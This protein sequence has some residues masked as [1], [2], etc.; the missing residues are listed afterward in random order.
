MWVRWRGTVTTTGDPTAKVSPATNTLTVRLH[1]NN[2]GSPGTVLETMTKAVTDA[3]D[4]VSQ[5][6][7]FVFSGVQT[8]TNGTTYHFT[9]T[10][11]TTSNKASHWEVAVDPT[12][13]SSKI[14]ADMSSPASATWAAPA[15]TFSL[16][17][18][19]ADAET[20]RKFFPF[21]LDNH[22]YAV[23]V[24]D[25]GVTASKLYINGDR[26][27]ATS[28][29]STTLTDTAFGVRAAGWTTSMWVNAKVRIVRGTGKGQVRKITANTTD[30]LTVGT[31][32]TTPD[33]TS[34][35]VIYS[36]PEWQELTVTGLG[37]V[38]GEPAVLGNIVYFPQGTTAIREMTLDYT[39]ATNHKYR[40]E[41]TNT[42]N[43]LLT[44]YN[45]QTNTAIVWRALNSSTAAT[46][47]F[48]PAVTWGSDLTF[49]T[50]INAGDSSFLI[51]GL[52]EKDNTLQIFK[53][54]GIGFISGN[55]Y[56]TIKSGQEDTPDDTNGIAS[57]AVDKFLYYNWLHSVIRVYGSSYDD[58]GQDYSSF[59]LPDFR[60]GVISYLDAYITTVL[61]AVDAGDGLTGKRPGSGISSVQMWDG[62]AW[63]ELFR[64]WQNGR[65]IRMA[66]VQPCPE[67]RNII[68]IDCGGEMIYLEMPLQKRD[69][70]L[71]SGMLYQHESVVESSI[72]DM[73][74][75]SD[76]PKMIKSLTATVKNLNAEGMEVYLD[77]QTDGDC[78]TATWVPASVLTQSPESTAW[79]GLQNIR[80]FVYRLRM[81]TDDATIPCD[82][83]GIV[84]SGY[85][86]TPLKL[87]WT[88]RVKAGGIYQSNS[89][90]APNSQ[91]LW[92]WL[93]DNARFPFAVLM[94]SKYEA[95]DGYHVIVH[96]PRMTPYKPAEPGQPEESYMSLVLEEI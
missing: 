70:L 35:Y 44:S 20:Q 29:T 38:T 83:E 68:W 84:P 22:M 81:C 62:L 52:N 79:L 74:A 60:E 12:G 30:T 9:V 80:R 40:S 14:T 47:S 31:W 61:A 37:V 24:K 55:A 13:T 54:N 71:D 15:S 42:A 43:L 72:I 53:Q 67:S 23:D 36:T 48:A 57:V 19:V 92:K 6:L 26:G 28:A 7:Q 96:P 49:G 76:M 56:V 88:M 93:M 21:F 32:D 85:A 17:Y 39:A 64:G 25:N 16:L 3:G 94:E 87:M 33:N 4:G 51:T 89:Q 1:A 78:H 5:L 95:A 41:A 18:R 27:K 58:I 63:H 91:K 2:S 46:V 86:R 65:R 77:Y 69:P 11:A 45:P 50:A 75:A 8:L 73:G 82:V 59:G 66:K 90:T 10:G 34:E